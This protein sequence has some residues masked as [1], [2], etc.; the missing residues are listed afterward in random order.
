MNVFQKGN[1]RL[2]A[3]PSHAELIIEQLKLINVRSLS[4]LGPDHADEDTSPGGSA[5]LVG[6]QVTLFRGVA[7][8][9]NYLA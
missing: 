4:S 7:A 3:D 1:L 6:K 8:G 2:E 9:C 5:D